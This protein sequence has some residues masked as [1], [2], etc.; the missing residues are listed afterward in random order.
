MPGLMQLIQG[1]RSQLVSENLKRAQ[2]CGLVFL[3]FTI[4]WFAC[5]KQTSIIPNSPQEVSENTISVLLYGESSHRNHLRPKC[6]KSD[7]EAHVQKVVN[8]QILHFLNPLADAGFDVRVLLATNACGDGWEDTL[9]QAYRPYLFGVTLSDC[10]AYANKRCHLYVRITPAKQLF[11][12]YGLH[13]N[14]SSQNSLRLFDDLSSKCPSCVGDVGDFVIMSRPDLIWKE[15]VGIPF[16][17]SLVSDPRRI[18]WPFRCVG[19]WKEWQCVADT[20]V[21]FPAFAFNAYR[22]ACVGHLSCHPDAY[23]DVLS[24]RHVFF[25]VTFS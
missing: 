22:S 7:Q 11:L 9:K 8:S 10:S 15:S 13:S 16:S 3:A 19:A 21:S 23:G 6:S 18:T 5:E 4:L 1:P 2:L 12:L 14:A 20:A 24:R 17:L 25:F